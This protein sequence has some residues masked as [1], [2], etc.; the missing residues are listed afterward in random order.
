MLQAF[1]PLDLGSESL[2]VSNIPVDMALADVYT[3]F[4]HAGEIADLRVARAADR[5]LVAIVWFI[6]AES[7]EAVLT[8]EYRGRLLPFA[9][10]RASRDNVAEFMEKFYVHEV[11]IAFAEVENAEDSEEEDFNQ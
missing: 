10:T 8:P 2:L 7:V 3:L 6:S 11:N 4:S 5:Q 1:I 9:I